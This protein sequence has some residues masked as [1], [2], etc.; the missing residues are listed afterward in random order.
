[1]AESPKPT[2]PREAMEFEP[3]IF[4]GV[5][6][7]TARRGYGWDLLGLT[8]L[9]LLPFFPQKLGG[10]QCILGISQEL[11]SSFGSISFRVILT[12]KRRPTN[13]GWVD[14][15]TEMV[16]LPN[17]EKAPVS[18]SSYAVSSDTRSHFFPLIYSGSGC[19]QIMPLPCPPLMLHEPG[20]VTVDIEVQGKQSRVGEF[21]CAFAPP[22]PLSADERRALASRPSALNGIGFRIGCTSCGQ[23]VEFYATLK[24]GDLRPR[25]VGA[26]AVPLLSAPDIWECTCGSS[27][28]ALSYMKQ[29]VHDIFRRPDVYRQR[30]DDLISFTPLY[31]EGRIDTLVAEYEELIEST[32]TEKPIQKFL[33][34]NSVF[35]AFLSPGRG[36]LHQPPVLT[37]KKA[38]FGILTTSKVL[39]LVEIEKPVTQLINR[40]GSVCAEIQ[41]GADQIRDW[42]L[43]VNDHRLA[44]LRELGFTEGE[45][46]EIRYI[47]VGGLA[48][49]T[50][51]EGLSKLRRSALAPK[52]QFFC[53]D[54][55][56]SFLRTIAGQF[57]NL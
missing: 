46:Q 12:D 31:E 49:R 39:Y 55:L 32:T 47:L 40:D 28:V 38:D 18:G 15:K 43:V 20:A 52:T 50:S 27:D 48:R 14:Q 23:E 4:L 45:V 29:G 8:G 25:N 7:R 57:R 2:S 36:I 3:P 11:L 42:E 26:N 30:E 54:E 56:G 13:K 51:A 21:L 9:V 24:P 44:L 34:K 5:S 37:K 19:V 1:M 6:G 41:K 17:P 35:W 16:P 33:E 22:A 53:F 10:L